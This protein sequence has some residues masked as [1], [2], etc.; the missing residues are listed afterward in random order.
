MLSWIR[1]I[2]LV[3]RLTGWGLIKPPS[4]R[5][6][7]YLIAGARHVRPAVGKHIEGIERR[8]VRGEDF[9]EG[10]PGVDRLVARF[11]RAAKHSKRRRWLFPDKVEIAVDHS[12]DQADSPGLGALPQASEQ[13]ASNLLAGAGRRRLLCLVE[14]GPPLQPPGDPECDVGVA[15]NAALPAKI[16]YGGVQMR[17]RHS[18]QHEVATLDGIIGLVGAEIDLQFGALNIGRV[19]TD[20]RRPRMDL[21]DHGLGAHDNL[22]GTPASRGGVGDGDADHVLEIGGP[23][24]VIADIGAIRKQVADGE[25][26]ACRNA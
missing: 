19:Y 24:L 3:L 18:V 13:Q 17:Y 4:N 1:T 15:Q 21:V 12:H 5:G 7:D 8:P 23:Q 9:R 22:V 20:D 6:R 16:V 25:N 14:S 26:V 11:A 2:S 10:G